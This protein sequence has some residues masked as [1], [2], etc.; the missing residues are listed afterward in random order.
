MIPKVKLEDK[1]PEI[2]GLLAFSCLGNLNDV[3]GLGPVCK[4]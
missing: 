4:K 3:L 1:I 2:A